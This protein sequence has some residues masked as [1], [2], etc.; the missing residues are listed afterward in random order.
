MVVTTLVLAAST[1]VLVLEQSSI[2]AL[3]GEPQPVAL[4]VTA[5]AS[6]DQITI[7]HEGGQSL[8]ASTIRIVVSNSS[9]KQRFTPITETAY[10]S[11][12]DEATI[13]LTRVGP[14]N[15]RVDWVPARDRWEYNQSGPF[16][17]ISPN[18]Q[19]T[20]RLIDTETETVVFETKVLSSAATDQPPTVT[21][22]VSADPSANTVAIDHTSGP[23]L[24]SDSTRVTVTIDGLS[25]TFDRTVTSSSLTAG[26]TAVINTTT[27]AGVDQGPDT[28]DWD[29]EAGGSEYT[30]IPG[31]PFPPID[32][33]DSITITITDVSSGTVLHDET[34]TA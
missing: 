8:D 18:E 21:L 34:I 28:I 24:D 2:D 15:N 12:G 30:S 20:I 23:T 26:E 16:S 33:G 11:T 17:G 1:G 10:L 29:P 25:Y 22:S 14:G 27:P 13:D 32:Q 3:L 5:D 9:T 7:E 4:S 6:T 19:L 31:N